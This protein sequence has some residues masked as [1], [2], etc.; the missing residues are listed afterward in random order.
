MKRVILYV[1]PF[2]R[3]PIGKFIAIAYII[4]VMNYSVTNHSSFKMIGLTHKDTHIVITGKTSPAFLYEIP[5]FLHEME[6]RQCKNTLFLQI[7]EP[8]SICSVMIL[9]CTKYILFYAINIA[10]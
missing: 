1:P 10:I 9:Y 8:P 7:M 5:G 3:V 4:Y 2:R 6:N